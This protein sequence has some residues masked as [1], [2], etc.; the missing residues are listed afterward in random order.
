MATMGH[1]IASLAENHPDIEIPGEI[2]RVVNQLTVAERRTSNVG[3]PLL[4]SMKQ[5]NTLKSAPLKVIDTM[6]ED[7]YRR[8]ANGRTNS[9][10]SEIKLR[11]GE[12]KSRETPYPLK[13]ALS[14]PNL[15]TKVSSFFAN[16]HNQIKQQRLNVINTSAE[17]TSNEKKS[18][19]ES[20]NG[21]V[22]T[23]TSTSV[24]L[25][26]PRSKLKPSHSS[27]ELRGSSSNNK[28]VETT[29]CDSNDSGNVTPTSPTLV[30]QIH[31]LDSCSDVHFTYGGTTKLKTIRP[32]KAQL[33]RNS[34]MDSISTLKPLGP[35]G[36]AGILTSTLIDAKKPEAS[37]LITG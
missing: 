2:R 29:K 9:A 4:K 11:P 34:S 35:G 30:A 8:V 25:A 6:G 23:D 21:T 12:D 22:T 18:A 10:G 31:P 27:F 24:P 32:L 13:S 14:S 7:A 19:V 5:E 33:S 3:Q 37:G 15:T 16:T 36:D 26:D 28:V 17:A 1:F 20:S